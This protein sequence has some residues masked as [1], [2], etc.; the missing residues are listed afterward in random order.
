LFE[1]FGF[2]GNVG[3]LLA[4]LAVLVVASDFTIKH[5]IKI[6]EVTGMGKTTV[7]F[8]LVGFSTS[9][10]NLSVAAFTYINPTRNIGLAIGDVLGSNIVNIALVLGVCIILVVL[11][12]TRNSRFMLAVAKEE[13]GSLNFGIFIASIVPLSLL[14]IGYASR[15]VG[16]FLI[17]I[18][19]FYMILLSRRRVQ[20]EASPVSGENGTLRRHLLF[21]LIGAIV[22]IASAF[23]IIDSATFI[24]T[25]VGVPSVLIGA[26]IVAFGTSIPVFSTSTASVRKGHFDL[27]LSNIIGECFMNISLILGVALIL[28]PE[29][30]VIAAFTNLV[31]FSLMT[32]MFLWYF[33]SS[34]R[35]SWREGALMLFLY[36]VFLAVS[37]GGYRV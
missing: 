4:S 17:A 13:M 32:N 27:A 19:I 31:L 29:V 21:E 30:V 16:M 10:A 26:T 23:F 15:F 2:I 28:T 1:D 3:I 18:F 8:V 25:S 24:A 35:I 7:G 14:Y 22:V 34:E 33:L 6:S 12:N 9:L 5:T 37:I 36:A 11:K 20:T